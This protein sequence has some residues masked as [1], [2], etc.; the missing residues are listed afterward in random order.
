MTLYVSK[1]NIDVSILSI[2]NQPVKFLARTISFT[3]SD[4]DQLEVISSAV[5]KGLALIDKSFHRG[6]NKVCILQHLLVPRLRCPFLIYEIPISAVLRLEQKICCYIRKWLKLHNSTNNICLNS[7]VSPFPLPIKSLTS[8]MKSKVSDH[9]L[10][11]KLSGPCVSG[12]SIDLKS[13]KW[14]VSDAVREAESTLEFKKIIGYHQSNRAGFGSK[15]TPEVPP[16]RSYAYRKLHSS[17][18]QETDKQKLQAKAA[19]LSLQGQW[20]EWCNFLRLDLSWKTMLAMPKT[21]LSFCLGATYDTLPSPSNLHRWCI[22]SEPS[23]YSCSKTVCTT[24]PILGACKFAL[25][26]GRFTYRHDSVLQ[27]FLT[28]LQTFLSS[29]SESLQHQINLVRPGTKIKKSMKK[30]HTGLLHLAPDWRVMSDFNKKLVIPSWI[31]IAQLTPDI[32]IFSKTQKS[33]IIIELTC[34]CE[35]NMEVWHQKKCQKD[36]PLSTSIKSNGWSVHLFVIEVGAKGYC[37]TTVKSSL[38]RLG[39]SGKFL[40]STI[41]K[42]SLSSLKASFQICLSRDCKRWL[43]EKVTISPIKTVSNVAPLSS[44]SASKTTK[45]TLDCEAIQASVKNCVVF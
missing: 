30:P 42:L 22:H 35:E 25:Q 40:K 14:K 3:V 38:C 28:A 2:S 37:S 9:L 29:V 27:A 24:A 4:K 45:I 34:P 26:Q 12:T 18:V 10:L 41:K 17:I 19:L 8:V 15:S 5:S 6:V 44:C 23:C 32:F 33:C 11:R 36:E 16:K 13:G 31:V 7:S 39:F 43:E 20:T 21:L 1:S